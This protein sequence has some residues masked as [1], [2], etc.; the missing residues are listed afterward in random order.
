M[1]SKR[2]LALCALALLVAVAAAHSVRSLRAK[3]EEAKPNN[4]YQ[5]YAERASGGRLTGR[6]VDSL[7]ANVINQIG[8]GEVVRL[9]DESNGKTVNV[10]L[11]NKNLMARHDGNAGKRLANQQRQ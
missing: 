2:A 3:E 7:I 6:E 4:F 11:G 1:Q 10:V 9:G 5:Q 8:R